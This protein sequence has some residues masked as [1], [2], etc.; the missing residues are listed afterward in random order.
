MLKRS[1]LSDRI[2]K[3]YAGDVAAHE[4][5]MF[6]IRIIEASII[7]RAHMIKVHV[8]Q[9]AT[10]QERWNVFG[11]GWGKHCIADIAGLKHCMWRLY[12]TKLR[13]SKIAANELYIADLG[14]LEVRLRKIQLVGV[15]LL[16]I[17]LV[18]CETTE[19][20][21]GECCAD[22]RSAGA[23]TAHDLCSIQSRPREIRISHSE[24]AATPRAL[25]P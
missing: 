1:V 12:P 18:W 17:P 14:E 8:A 20:R 16:I 21:V 11:V 22:E 7:E 25:S 15:G 13:L 24:Q 5:N 6:E 4:R 19:H 23:S 9:I 2:A 3:R 10:P